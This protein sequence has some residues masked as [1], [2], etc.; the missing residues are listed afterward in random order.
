MASALAWALWWA[1]RRRSDRVRLPFARARH[2][3]RA[4]P[5]ADRDESPAAWTA[6]HRALDDTAGGTVHRGSI[7][8]LI[9]A[10]PWL[11]A[12]RADIERFY[13]ASAARFFA[14]PPRPEP[15]PVDALGRAL[16]R[17]EKRQ[18]R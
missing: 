3:L 7:G 10:A 17:A 8:R 1:W 5:L 13:A 16:Y 18:A 6:L 15:F 11:A 4:I 12:S 9:E 2:A 14:R